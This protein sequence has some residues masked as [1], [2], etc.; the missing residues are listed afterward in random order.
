MALLLW[1][2]QCEQRIVGNALRDN[3]GMCRSEEHIAE[4]LYMLHILRSSR[5]VSQ[6]GGFLLC[7]QEEG[8]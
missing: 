1:I 7:C 6:H 8:T 3:G 2:S 4:I 5:V